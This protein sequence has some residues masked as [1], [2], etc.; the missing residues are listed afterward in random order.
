M[1]QEQNKGLAPQKILTLPFG[2]LS[3]M[4]DKALGYLEPLLNL[5]YKKN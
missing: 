4:G 5:T 1:L 3:I 2:N